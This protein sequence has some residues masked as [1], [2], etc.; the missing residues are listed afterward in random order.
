[1]D[2]I[3]QSFD[4][5]RPIDY[6]DKKLFD[7]FIDIAV[8]S[9]Y[10]FI[11]IKKNTWSTD[12]ENECPKDITKCKE[13]IRA[14]IVRLVGASRSTSDVS[15]QSS[16]ICSEKTYPVKVN[17]KKCIK[18]NF[19]DKI[20]V[21]T[22]VGTTLDIICGLIYL[23]SK[24]K[25]MKVAFENISITDT[26]KCDFYKKNIV[27]G[28]GSFECILEKYFIT[29]Y[30]NILDID[31]VVEGIVTRGMN[32]PSID[33]MV[34]FIRLVYKNGG[35]HANILLYSKK[36]NELE[37]F[38]P[39][40]SG[41][42]DLLDKKL[43]TY[44]GNLIPKLKYVSP[45][46]YMSTVGFQKIDVTESQ[47]EYIGDPEGYCV[48]WSMWYADM[49]TTFTDISRTKLIKY[50][51]QQIGEKHMKYRS[52]I[53]NYSRNITK[54]RD[55]LLNVADL[56]INKYVNGVYNIIDATKIVDE[57]NAML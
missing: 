49:R 7:K 43:E 15:K 11:I 56:D 31:P 44:F 5:T 26:S 9:Y 38:D 25:N 45:S 4:H 46:D 6:V 35:G 42:D 47:N 51:I 3:V 28:N 27:P 30:K 32:N 24:H 21:N 17:T 29:W 54:I 16:V 36:T 10:H 18:I 40:G 20:T 33:F 52:I 41:Q 22:M 34:F 50:I 53:R 14:K 23:S 37:R 12:W 13:F 55:K 39:F 8:E 1:L 2:I 57:I 48:S 19:D